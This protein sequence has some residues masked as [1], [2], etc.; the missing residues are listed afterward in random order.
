VVA[1]VAAAVCT[2]AL[3]GLPGECFESL[4]RDARPK[5]IERTLSPLCV[6]T[7]LIANRLQLGN[8]ILQ[9]RI[10]EIGDAVLD[11]VVQPLEFGVCLGRTLAKFGDMR[12]SALGALLAA[13]E[14]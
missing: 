14:H 1:P 12:C 8:A 7:G 11:G 3:A 6:S 4:W 2:H 10:R 9:Q 13:V 5:P